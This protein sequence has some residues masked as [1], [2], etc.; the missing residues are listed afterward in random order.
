MTKYTIKVAMDVRAFG[1]VKVEAATPEDALAEC[2]APFIKE[3]FQPHGSGS[4]DYDMEHP[5]DIV[6]T[7]MEDENDEEVE[8]FSE[9]IIDEYPWVV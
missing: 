5:T 4:D 8:G 2:T 3:N 1:Y 7:E 9:V 6:L